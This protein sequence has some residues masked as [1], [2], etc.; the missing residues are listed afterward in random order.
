VGLRV[1]DFLARRFG[2][3]RERGE[4]EC[5]EEAEGLLGAGPE[6]GWSESERLAWGRWA[7]LVCVLPGVASWSAAERS[8]LAEVVRAKGGQRESEFVLRFDR[9]T[10]LRSAIQELA[11]GKAV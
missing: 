3:D 10:K 11:G 5:S 8:A 1:T 6:R 4:R 2:S 9:H 7:P